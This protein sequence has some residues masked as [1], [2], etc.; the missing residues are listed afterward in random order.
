[1]DTEI[2]GYYNLGSD[3]DSGIGSSS[4]LTKHN[5]EYVKVANQYQKMRMLVKHR[6]C[7][8]DINGYISKH[9][10]GICKIDSFQVAKIKIQQNT[11]F[12]IIL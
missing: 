3:V 10:Y 11:S 9:M 5:G 6:L 2:E 1:M 7:M 4:S 12:S 8:Y